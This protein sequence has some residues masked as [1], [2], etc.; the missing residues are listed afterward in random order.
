MQNAECRKGRDALPAGADVWYVRS[1]R[2]WKLLQVLLVQ[3][4]DGENGGSV[5]DT[6]QNRTFPDIGLMQIAYGGNDGE[7]RLEAEL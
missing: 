5:E 1:A 3:E 7:D 2:R 4:V 6:G